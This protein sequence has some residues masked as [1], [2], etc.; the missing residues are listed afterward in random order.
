MALLI[1]AHPDIE[2]SL[3]N[4]TIIESLNQK[5]M[6]I[7]IR[8]IQK[9]YPDFK[10]D[11]KKEQEVLLRHD[12]IVFQFPFYWYGVPAI[13]KQ[14][15]DVVLEYGF[16]YGSTGDKLKGK[17]FVLSF[18]VGSSEKEYSVLGEH[19]FRIHEFCKSFEQIAYYTKMNYVEPFYF[20]GT[21]LNA[22]YSKE[23]I[24]RNAEN[25]AENLC[26]LLRTL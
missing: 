15:Y 1:L 14:W 12:T 19:H 11:A 9:R 26:S 13:L 22:G 2:K 7:E 21:S 25:Q 4:K 8:D 10:I 16:A 23:E 20:Y 3:A 17:N 18:T 5:N 6:D 24:I